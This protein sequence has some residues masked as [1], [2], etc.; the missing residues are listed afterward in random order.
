M[1]LLDPFI[2]KHFDVGSMQARKDHALAELAPA[3]AVI[4]T[5]GDTPRD[6]FHAGE[7]LEHA[8]LLATSAG[9]SASFLNQPLHLEHMRPAIAKLL[10]ERGHPQVIVRLGHGE[11]IGPTPRRAVEEVMRIV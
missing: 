11:N 9:L 4:G 3:I 8:L 1:S 5:S 6:W 2:I 7:A 10:Q